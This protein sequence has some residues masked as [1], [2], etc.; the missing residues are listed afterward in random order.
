MLLSIFQQALSLWQKRGMGSQKN[1]LFLS[2][3]FQ[4]F[5]FFAFLTFGNVVLRTHPESFYADMPFLYLCQGNKFFFTLS[6]IVIFIG[7][8]TTLLSLCL[9]LKESLSNFFKS[10]VLLL[11]LSIFLPFLISEC[12]FL[13][14]FLISIQFRQLWQFSFFYFLYRLSRRLTRKYIKK[15]SMQ[16]TKVAVI[17]RSILKICPP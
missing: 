17:T 2:V 9:T 8:L 7:C 12:G 15:A 14:S 16:R 1:R 6:Y 10:E 4:V 5:F 3:C 11:S 13:I